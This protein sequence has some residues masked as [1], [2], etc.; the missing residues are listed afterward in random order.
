MSVDAQMVR[1]TLT[2]KLTFLKIARPT[3]EETLVRRSAL[4]RQK[5]ITANLKSEQLLPYDFPPL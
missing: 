1:I 5:A 3:S 2:Q 4:Q